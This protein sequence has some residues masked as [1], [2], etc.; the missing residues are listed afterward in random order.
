MHQVGAP[1]VERE[2]ETPLPA[3]VAVPA[4]VVDL[5]DGND[6]VLDGDPQECLTSQEMKDV[7]FGSAHG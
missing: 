1:L 5:E 7:Y 3:A 4:V 6:L 2:V